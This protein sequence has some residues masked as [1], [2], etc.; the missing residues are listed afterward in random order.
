MKNEN[1]IDVSHEIELLFED[2]AFPAEVALT[3]EK[4]ASRSYEEKV[5]IL[6]EVSEFLYGSPDEDAGIFNVDL[7][8]P[9]VIG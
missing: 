4:W 7:N 3:P 2:I 6:K 8:D 1:N 9:E 5:N